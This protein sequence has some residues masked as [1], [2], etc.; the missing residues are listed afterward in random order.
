MTIIARAM[1]ITKLDSNLSESQLDEILSKY[2]DASYAEQ[3][4]KTAIASCIAAKIAPGRSDIP[5][6]PKDF[7]TR[8]EV[9]AI[10]QRLLK[11][12]RFIE[13]W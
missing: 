12:L 4:A 2:T 9:A 11:H 1:K 8:A 10:L 6:V 5:I 7:I 3:Y 13:S